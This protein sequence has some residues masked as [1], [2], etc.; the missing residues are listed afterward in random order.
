MRKQ[1]VRLLSAQLVMPKVPGQKPAGPER[2]GWEPCL[3]PWAGLGGS[4][5]AGVPCPAAAAVLEPGAGG[6]QGYMC[7]VRGCGVGVWQSGAVR[8]SVVPLDKGKCWVQ[9]L[10]TGPGRGFQLAQSFAGCDDWAAAQTL[11]SWHFHCVPA[12]ALP[13]PGYKVGAPLHP[14]TQAC[15]LQQEAAAA[16]VRGESPRAVALAPASPKGGRGKRGF[17]AVPTLCPPFL[18]HPEPARYWGVQ[19]G[20]HSPWDPLLWCHQWGAHCRSSQSRAVSSHPT[21]HRWPQGCTA[22][23]C[24]PRHACVGWPQGAPGTPSDG[25]T[26]RALLGIVG[27]WHLLWPRQDPCP[28]R[29]GKL[30]TPTPIAPPLGPCPH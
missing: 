23:C 12:C 28:V 3:V 5:R 2:W 11:M 26:L 14:E 6:L 19:G 4:H 13:L 8:S 29:R 27:S 25:A 17:L 15:S 1:R 7:S 10:G 16:Q 20:S 9:R 18:E 21:T 22:A 30:L 24:A